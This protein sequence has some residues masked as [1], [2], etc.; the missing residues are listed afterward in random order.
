[1][2]GKKKYIF[3]EE[4]GKAVQF[5]PTGKTNLAHK[6]KQKRRVLGGGEGESGDGC[7]R[8]K[9]GTVANMTSV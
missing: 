6:N 7:R 9:T 5:Q 8:K 4:D 2:G 3:D 1:V